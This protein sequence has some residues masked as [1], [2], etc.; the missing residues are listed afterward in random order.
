[1]GYGSW[2]DD[3]IWSSINPIPLD[4]NHPIYQLWRAMRND[5]S[6]PNPGPPITDIIDTGDPNVGAQQAFSSG[7]VLGV[8]G[9]G[10]AYV[11]DG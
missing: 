4:T 10:Q 5:P 8:G 3:R 11:A 2:L 7:M 6:Q 1:M 9:D